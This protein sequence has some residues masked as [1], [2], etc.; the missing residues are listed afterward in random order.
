VVHAV[1]ALGLLSS[2]VCQEE[3]PVPGRDSGRG[4]WLAR[5]AG[6]V[7]GLAAGQSIGRAAGPGA[8]SKTLRGWRTAD[9]LVGGGALALFLAQLSVDTAP[10]EL[11]RGRWS[12]CREGEGG[13]SNRECALNAVDAAVRSRLVA[14]TP[15][16]RQRAARISD[17]TLFAAIA[18]PFAV[19]Q[20]AGPDR[21]ERD[22]LVAAETLAVTVL[23]NEA[24]TRFFDRPRPFVPHRDP[25]RRD[26]LSQADARDSFYSGHASAS[27]AMAVAAGTMSH[28][29]GYRH[30]GWIWA[31]GLTLATTTGVLRIVADKHYLTD[32]A[33]GA[34]V[35]GLAGWLIPRLHRPESGAGPR[36]R[37]A[38][39]EGA[40]L[41]SLPFLGS[42]R[43][44]GLVR[45]G[46]AGGPFAEVTWR[47]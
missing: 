31:T 16:G 19:T 12:D 29:H 43:K 33:V 47:W 45:A 36:A 23:L 10:E 4:A 2:S 41:L 30:E 21:R 35:G 27:F 20:G 26:E 38:P 14:A 15:E 13:A 7:L 22:V 25:L 24:A 5:S 17:T 1:L 40:A 42:G 34:A 32:V 18:F 28:F 37:P 9:A 44:A 39:G 11:A 6:V 3:T 8:T 46:F